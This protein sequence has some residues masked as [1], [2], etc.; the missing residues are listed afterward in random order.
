MYIVLVGPSGSRKGTAM[1]PGRRLLNNLGIKIAAEST[2]REALVRALS[3]SA[4]TQYDEGLRLHCSLTIYSEEFTVFLGYN[5]L[6]MMSDLCDWYDCKE[7]WTYRTKGA[8]TDEIQGVW[9]NLFGATTPSLLQSSLP[10]DAIGGGLTSRMIFVYAPGKGKTV[11]FPFPTAEEL[12]VLAKL[13]HDLERIRMMSGEF[14]VTEGFMAMWKDWYTKA[15]IDLP[16]F[17]NPKFTGYIERR[18]THAIKLSMILSAS[19]SDSMVID[20][21]DLLRA[22]SML[23]QVEKY[24]PRVFQGVGQ[25]RMAPTLIR[26]MKFLEVNKRVPRAMLQ[27][28]FFEDA[29]RWEMDD[30]LSTMSSMGYIYY[31][32]DAKGIQYIDWKGE[33]DGNKQIDIGGD[34]G[35]TLQLTNGGEDNGGRP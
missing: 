7:H 29:S 13:E 33:G 31:Y 18:A 8:G 19:R 14:K 15:D 27:R 9:V 12:E 26:V 28:T 25:N 32:T 1:G 35:D 22:T 17:T 16:I 10:L 34:K 20:D 3:E 21:V 6:Q 23:T 30:I 4:D 5:N 11:A 24:M 2:T